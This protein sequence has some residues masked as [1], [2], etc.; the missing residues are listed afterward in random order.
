MEDYSCCRELIYD[1]VFAVEV[2]VGSLSFLVSGF[3]I[4]LDRK[5]SSTDNAPLIHCPSIC[6]QRVGVA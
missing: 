6:Q 2:D 3:P 5:S 4:I 1:A